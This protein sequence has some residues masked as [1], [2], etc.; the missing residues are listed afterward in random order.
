MDMMILIL[1]NI[2]IKI[3]NGVQ[4]AIL[5]TSEAKINK[6]KKLTGA[7]C[8]TIALILALGIANPALAAKL[9]IGNVFEAIEKNL[10]FPGN[11]SQYATSVNET[12][13]SNGVDI[14]LSEILCDG[15]YLY[16][17]Y[18]VEIK[19][20]LNIPLGEIQEKWI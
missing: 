9:P 15:Q 5:E 13:T 17:T 10:F 19:I 8:A 6:K 18:I 3:H 11:Y 2:D 4:K 7:I 16:V 20:H 1:K 14:T 12:T